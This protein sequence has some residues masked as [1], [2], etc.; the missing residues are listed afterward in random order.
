MSASAPIPCYL[1]SDASKEQQC[2]GF[3][4]HLLVDATVATMANLILLYLSGMENTTPAFCAG[5]AAAIA[6]NGVHAF[7]HYFVDDCKDVGLVSGLAALILFGASTYILS[8]ISMEYFDLKQTN[9]DILIY[10]IIST[11][12]I[13]LSNNYL[14]SSE[15]TPS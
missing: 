7:T 10:S 2:V 3:V 6:L 1:H 5:P 11:V 13:S 9:W 8:D 12:A 4:T 14:I 15:P